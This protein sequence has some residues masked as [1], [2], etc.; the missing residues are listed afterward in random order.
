MISVIIPSYNRGIYLKQMILSVLK[1]EGVETEIIVIDDNSTDETSAIMTDLQQEYGDIRYFRNEINRG[2]G[3]SRLYGYN[4]S[5]GEYVVFA[6]D[7][8]YYTDRFFYKK[9]I[10][11]LEKN[12]QLALVSG[13]SDILYVQENRS[14]TTKLDIKGEINNEEY[15]DGFMTRYKKPNSTFTTMFRRAS[16]D[17]AGLFTMKMVND[18]S[19]YMRALLCGNMYVMDDI[20]GVYRVHDGNITNNLTAQF[21]IDNLEEKKKIWDLSR[22]RGIC[23]SPDWLKKQFL[24]TTIY[25]FNNN[26]YTFSD[27]NRIFHWGRMNKITSNK[28]KLMQCANKISKMLKGR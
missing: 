13:N 15:L 22:E 11:E 24:V 26:R 9:A 12:P 14:A 16:L 23:L 27:I 2:P 3:Y 8:D 21:I 19:I 5:H 25:F 6:D 20:I 17:K 4:L 18:A 28:D 1:M 10:L 7:D